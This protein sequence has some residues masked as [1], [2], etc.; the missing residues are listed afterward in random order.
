LTAIICTHGTIERDG[1]LFEAQS[2]GPRFWPLKKNGDP[3][4]AIPKRLRPIM[5]ELCRMPDAEFDAIRYG[6]E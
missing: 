2:I 1:V 4:L 6:Q 3:Y 5:D